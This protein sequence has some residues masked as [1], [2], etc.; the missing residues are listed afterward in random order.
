MAKSLISVVDDDPSMCRMLARVLGAAGHDVK[1][2]NSAEEFLT[3]ERIPRSTCLIL[4]VDLPGMSGVE[5]QQRVN[6]STLDIPIIFI[7]G[8]ADEHAREAV[9]RA[10]AVAFFNKP[11]SI[12]SLLAIINSVG[13]VAQLS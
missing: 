5:L 7:S 13:P 12:N 8:Q 6:E 4:D 11:F 9:L 2:F 1:I 10:G 3:S